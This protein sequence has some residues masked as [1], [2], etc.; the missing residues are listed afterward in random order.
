MEN[1]VSN[2]FNLSKNIKIYKIKEY[3]VIFKDGINDNNIISVSKKSTLCKNGKLILYH[4]K[5]ELNN[6]DN[7]TFCIDKKVYDNGIF[8]RKWK[9]GDRICYNSKGN[10]KKVKKILSELN[11]LPF[12][13]KKIPILVNK[14]DEIL[15]ILGYKKSFIDYSKIQDLVTLRWRLLKWILII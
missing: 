12:D 2:Y 5:N 15:W 3:L 14:N 4:Y 13:K 6:Y 11:I 10:T 7:N 8:I 9:N 1:I